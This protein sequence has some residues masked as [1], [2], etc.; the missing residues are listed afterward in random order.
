MVSRAAGGITD[1]RNFSVAELK[2]S[3]LEQAD[4]VC[5]TLSGAGSQP[6]LEVV[7]KIPGF[8][9]HAVIIDEAAQAVEP[10]TLIPF[11]FNPHR[12]VMVGDPCQLP[13]T[14]FSRQVG[15]VTMISHTMISCTMTLYHDTHTMTLYHTM[16]LTTA[17]H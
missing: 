8:K 17:I 14:V 3:I 15:D 13:A 10:S 5:A 1:S 6:I 4:V 2:K 12:V 7:M 9:F 11:K 16:A